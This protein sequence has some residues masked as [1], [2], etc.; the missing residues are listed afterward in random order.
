[1]RSLSAYPKSFPSHFLTGIFHF[2]MDLV[3]YSV[4]TEQQIILSAELP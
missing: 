2:M 4:E 3:I 1:M